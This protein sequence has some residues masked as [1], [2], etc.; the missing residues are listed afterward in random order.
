MAQGTCSIEGC[1]RVGK[2]TRGWCGKHYQAWW[3]HGDPLW[4]NEHLPWPEALLR[5]MAPQSNGCIYFTGSLHWKGYG[6][7]RR[8]GRT[9]RAHRLAYEHFVGPIPDG[10]TI[11]HECHNRD[12]TC[13]GG[14]ACL[15][16]RCVNPEHLRA[17]PMG[18]NLAASRHTTYWKG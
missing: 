15:H 9:Q 14:N 17:V 2:I 5:R 12:K 4:G 10:M 6:E 3:K 1:G 11:D 7:L 16:R 8:D 18:V 13:D